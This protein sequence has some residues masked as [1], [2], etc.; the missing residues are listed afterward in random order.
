MLS[1]VVVG[2]ND[3][4]GYNLSKRA[5]SS[6][7]SIA[8]PMTGNDELIFIDWNS[9]EVNPTFI[10]SIFDTLTGQAQKHI[11]VYRIRN[12][13][14][15]KLAGESQRP[16]LEPI[17]RNVGI[18]RAKNPWILST[19]TDMVF[20][21]HGQTYSEILKVLQ[22]SVYHLFRYEIPEYIWEQFDRYDPESTI[23][24]FLEV[25]KEKNLYRK[26]NTI[27]F[28]GSTSIFPDAVGDFQL[29]PKAFGRKCRAFRRKCSKD[30]MLIPDYLFRWRE[31][32]TPKLKSSQ[33]M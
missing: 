4:H 14:H 18:R 16:I 25:I 23:T 3:S 7:N 5:A 13:I 32:L 21:T 1:V 19:N 8:K 27:P 29:A 28:E 11:I 33:T 20:D 15:R 12:H 2:R 30:G 22:P 6:L 9:D 10:E 26:L 31:C 17:A 24:N